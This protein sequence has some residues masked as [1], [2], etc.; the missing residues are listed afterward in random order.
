ML[1]SGSRLSMPA[2]H[3]PL[4]APIAWPALQVISILHHHFSRHHATGQYV[5]TDFF[6][7]SAMLITLVLCGKYLECSAK[8]RT[9]EALT[10]LMRLMPE[11]ATVSCIEGP[12][13]P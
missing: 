12:F 3:R 6:E 1:A 9:S 2:L 5:P 11:S 13:L 10:R 7:T 8:G 4:L